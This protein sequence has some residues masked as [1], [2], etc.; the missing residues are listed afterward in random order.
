MQ[1]I[2]KDGKYRWEH[3]IFAKIT[4]SVWYKSKE[5][6]LLGWHNYWRTYRRPDLMRWKYSRQLGFNQR[7]LYSYLEERLQK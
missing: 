5:K 6:C 3:C 7:H 4:H 1:I 2:E